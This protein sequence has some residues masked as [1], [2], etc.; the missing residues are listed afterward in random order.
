[1]ECAIVGKTNYF[2]EVRAMQL[3]LSPKDNIG[4]ICLE[5]VECFALEG[6]T[7]LVVF[8]SGETRNYPLQHLWYYSSHVEFHKIEV[9]R[10]GEQL[11]DDD[12]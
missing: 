6:E 4:K 7:L 11:G 9:S 8:E 1:M 10:I 5:D 12:E 2:R 3:V